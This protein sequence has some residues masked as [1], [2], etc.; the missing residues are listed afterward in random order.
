MGSVAIVKIVSGGQT[1]ADRAAL[2]W[3]IESNIPHGGWCPAGRRAED[4]VIGSRYHLKETPSR[5]FTQRT[6]WNVRDSDGTL[7][8][9]LDPVLTTGS[10]QTLEFARKLGRPCLHLHPQTHSAHRLR[11]FVV[12]HLIGILNVAGSRESKEPGISR[13]VR[14]LLSEAN[15]GT[16]P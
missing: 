7:I 16:E 13:Y 3:A 9:S 15:I 2:D 12:E 8:V 10:K 5:S 11:D 4:G 6:H 14:E 1:G